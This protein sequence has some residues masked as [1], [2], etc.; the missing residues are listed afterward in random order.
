[1]SR[2]DP[3]TKLVI[4]ALAA[5][6]LPVAPLV[7]ILPK[8]EKTFD[9]FNTEL[10]LLT[11]IVM[12]AGKWLGGR[13]YPDQLIPGLAW[14]LLVT[15]IVA[16]WLGV[17]VVNAPPRQESLER[18]VIWMFSWFGVFSTILAVEVLVIVLAVFLP[19]TKLV[20]GLT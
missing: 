9:D 19:I 16:V 8:F 13:L 12:N 15:V 5:I 4:A 14:L 7:F 3:L 6:W 10:P 2:F 17:R 18:R 20:E 11:K 1:M